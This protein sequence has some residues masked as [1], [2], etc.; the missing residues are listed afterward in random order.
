VTGGWRPGENAPA[1]PAPAAGVRVILDIRPLQDPERAPLTA[2][3]LEAL[4]TALD[5]EPA[6]GESY[7][8]LVSLDRD[9]PTTRW[10]NLDVI[11]RRRLPPTRYLRS[12]SLTVDPLLLRGASVGAGW[13]A[14]RGGAAGSVYHAAGGALPIGSGIPVVAALLDLAPWALPDDY[15]R[16]TAVRFGQR[17]RARILRDAAAVLVPGRAV[18]TE[19]R[20]LLH[21]KADRLRVIPLAPRPAFRPDAL[22]AGLAERTRLGL[23][24][25][26]AVYA[27]RF[28]ARQ[29]L[30]TLLDALARLAAAPPPDGVPP[31]LW[32]PRTALVGASPSDRAALSRAA[33]RAGVAELLAYAQ[34][35]P[36]ERLAGLVAAARVVLQPVR[37]DATGL[38][39]MEALASGVP[40]IASAVGALPEIVGSAGILV[41]PGDPVRLAAAIAAAWA[42]ADPYPGL[43]AAA[44]ERATAPR[45]WADVARETRATWADVARPAP[46]L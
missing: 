45:T 11:G 5:A 22:G 7:S 33:S 9:D 15:Q 24:A 27:G 35:L 18:A 44:R 1:A 38:V 34:G 42:D 36:D 32:P 31:E 8:F 14:E 20:R 12:G 26:Y 46:L 43:V 30:P 29:D 13:K 4:L 6:E 25:R 28:D 2:L 3:Y 10:S 16:G 39:A 21:V 19:A 40:V 23:P 17:L 41:E 37:S